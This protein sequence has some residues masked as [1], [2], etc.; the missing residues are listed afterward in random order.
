MKLYIL[1]LS[2]IQAAM[3]NMNPDELK[4]RQEYLKQQRD[5]LLEM[6]KKEREKQLLAAEKSQPKRPMSARMAK[7]AMQEGPS[8]ESDKLSP[9]EEKKMAMRKAIA[10]RLKAEMLGK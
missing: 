10:D 2:T 9:E 4:K 6:K 3:S 8:N 5:K 7:S 1:L